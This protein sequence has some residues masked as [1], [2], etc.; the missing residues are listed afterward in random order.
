MKNNLKRYYRHKALFAVTFLLPLILCTLFGFIDFDQVSLRVG[1][2]SAE[3][4]PGDSEPGEEDYR[5]ILY[6]VLDQSKGITFS[7]AKEESLN[8]DLM[9]G[10]YQLVL[11][12]RSENLNELRVIAYKPEKYTAFLQ[13]AVTT[14]VVN[15]EPLMLAGLKQKGLQ[16][17]ERSTT[18]LL[19]LFMVFSILYASL[20]IRDK[21]SG[22][23]LRYQY[24]KNTKVDY[25]A[26]H[27]VSVFSMTLLQVLICMALLSILSD[28][29]HL[30]L[31]EFGILAVA[32]AGLATL[33]SVM[34]C[35]IS[36]SEVQAGVLAS[37]A[38]VLMSLLGGTFVAVE[39]MPW[40][41]RMI[42]YA[43]P[44]RWVV[45]LLQLI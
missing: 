13:K 7:R 4:L 15:Q 42:S 26:G 37:S 17:T 36:K 2:L 6:Q 39:S 11:D 16:E 32:I 12:C 40:L 28:G 45:E 14:A 38:A 27:I 21:Q 29:F 10:H 22:T 1:V 8:M 30:S 9:T 20:L 35:M 23:Y 18:M 44:M 41:L 19:T 5:A 24:A 3:E 31:P 34:I 43:S 25:I 33:S